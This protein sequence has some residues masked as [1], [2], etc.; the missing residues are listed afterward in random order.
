MDGHEASSSSS[1]RDEVKKNLFFPEKAVQLED[2]LVFVVTG[3]FSFSIVSNERVMKQICSEKDLVKTL[4]KY[5]GVLNSRVGMKFSALTTH[6]VA[7]V[8]DGLNAGSDILLSSSLPVL[9]IVRM[10]TNIYYLLFH[11]R[12]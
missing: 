9:I 3:L 1:G 12:N 11:F 4:M 8:L 6:K 2:I 5:K 7:T 10:D